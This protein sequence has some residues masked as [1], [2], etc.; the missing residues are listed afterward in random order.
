MG[1]PTAG[2]TRDARD[3]DRRREIL[4]NFRS[5]AF[6]EGGTMSGM[7]LDVQTQQ[8]LFR[9]KERLDGVLEQEGAC[10]DPDELVQLCRDF[11]QVAHQQNRLSV[12]TAVARKM[13]GLLQASDIRSLMPEIARTAGTFR[14]AYER[15]DA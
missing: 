9:L 11:L 3:V 14:S 10:P 13:I 4:L 12:I 8:A 15:L 7:E 2:G 1:P 5:D 6:Q